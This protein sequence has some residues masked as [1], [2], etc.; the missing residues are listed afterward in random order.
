M[1]IIDIIILIVLIIF[2]LYGLVSGF[3]KMIVLIIGFILGLFFGYYLPKAMGFTFPFN[4]IFGIVIFI[5]FWF[6]FGVIAHFVGKVGK[7]VPFNTIGGGIL[8]LFLG[9]IFL[10][11]I[12]GYLYNNVPALHDLIEESILSRFISNFISFLLKFKQGGK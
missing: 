9:S 10:F 6:I 12:L 11:F 2:A 7:I 5:I 8:G 3:F 1:N 4:F